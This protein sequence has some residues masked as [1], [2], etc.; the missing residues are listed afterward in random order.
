MKGSAFKR[1]SCKD[2]NTGKEL[3]V[4]CPDLDSRRHGTWGYVVW[5]DTST[6]R[7]QLKRFGFDRKSDGDAVLQAID[8]LV[9]LADGDADVRVRIGDLIVAKTMRGGQ[10][11]AKADVERRLGAGAPLERSIT[12]AEWLDGWLA[13][14]R[15]I[16]RSTLRCY[17][18]HVRLYFKPHLG[19]IPLDKLRVTH[20]RAMFDAIDA[21]NAELADLQARAAAGEE[22]DYDRRRRSS[23]R[24]L[25]NASAPPCAPPCPTRADRACS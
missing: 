22:I 17:E 7:R 1:C 23:A 10:L 19:Q 18:A 8:E 9:R 4:R 25:S 2:P 13:G 12:V 5:L 21:A 20:L 16:R 24:P 14:K 15:K 3:G 11:P 6:G